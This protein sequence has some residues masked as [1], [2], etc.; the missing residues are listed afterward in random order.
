MKKRNV[1]IM[2]AGGR[3]FHNFI[4]YFKDNPTYKVIC[5]TATQIPGIS[6]RSFP[7]CLTGRLYRSDIPIYPEEKLPY[8][9]KKHKI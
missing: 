2:G 3:D 7:R 6:K 8:L 4:T 1:I 5:F 9:I